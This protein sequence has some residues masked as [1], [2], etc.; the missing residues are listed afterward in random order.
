MPLLLSLRTRMRDPC[1]DVVVGPLISGQKGM[2][3]QKEADL[4]ETA[5]GQE[6][7]YVVEHWAI[8]IDRY[9]YICICTHTY[10]LPL[11]YIC[12][13]TY[14]QIYR[15][16][17]SP[18]CIYCILLGRLGGH[19][20]KGASACSLGN[21]YCRCSG[22]VLVPLLLLQLP[23]PLTVAASHAS[24]MTVTF[25]DLDCLRALCMRT[26]STGPASIHPATVAATSPAI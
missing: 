24:S 8:E 20:A 13:Y 9:M 23:P 11:T 16:C 19:F 15:H 2:T 25:S 17:G 7:K 10:I 21:S 5:T 4:L 14:V 22:F 3:R 1:V 18:T 6:S 26:A 12:T